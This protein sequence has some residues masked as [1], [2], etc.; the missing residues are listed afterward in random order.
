MNYNTK[1]KI[2]RQ[3]GKA[4]KWST[5]TEVLARLIAPL[6]NMV[7]ARLLT[8]EAFGLVATVTMVV[9]FAEVFTDAGFQ[10]YLVQHEFQDEEDLNVSTNVAFWTN[11]IFSLLLFGIIALFSSP[12]A[13]LVGSAGEGLSV[14][15]A[16]IAIPLVSFSSIQMARCRRD[17]DFKLLFGVR[18]VT[19]LVP[20][21]VTVPLAFILKSH[22]AL[23]IGT[24]FREALN[25]LILML[26]LKWKPRFS[27]SF[28]K[29]REMFSFTAWSMLEQLSL[30]LTSNV[31]IFIVGRV[32]DEYYLGLYKT[33]MTTVNAYMAIITAATTPVLFSALSR[34]QHDEENFR[35]IFFRFQRLVAVLVM[36]MGMGLYLYRQLATQILLGSDWMEVADFIGM[37]ALVSSIAIVFMQYSGE[38]YRSKGKPKL[39]LLSQLILLVFLVGTT[40]W[41]APKG[42]EALYIGRTLVRLPSIVVSAVI[43]WCCFKISFWSV[44]KNTAAPMIAT[45]GMGG[46]G[47]ALQ[48]I[49]TQLWWS[50]VSIFL[51]I[52]VY[53]VILLA[54]PKQRREI[55]AFPFIAKILKKLPLHRAG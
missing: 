25:A 37:W 43:M 27:Y 49:S 23:I 6:T 11:F 18:M 16:C 47:W 2:S 5:V 48:Q 7:L 22:W 35:N 36:P 42:F 21:V 30:W 52:I 13:A 24:L 38:V 55:F 3:V 41:L 4:V 8:P 15:V 46:V 19:S 32:L 44:L 40:L 20:L 53:F 29:L 17:F 28:A 10:K 54:F 14:T 51:C 45:L 26:R 9:T 33:S 34:F 50:I 12:I 1:E 31:D 39:S